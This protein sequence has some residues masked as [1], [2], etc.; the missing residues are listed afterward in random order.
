MSHVNLTYHIVWRTKCS[1][2]TINENN[3]RELYKYIVGICKGKNSHVYRINSMPDHIHLCVE[4]PPTIAVSTFMQ[5][6][7]QESSK[8]M[9]EHGELFPYFRGWGNGYAAFTYSSVE[10]L[11]VIDYIANQKEHHKTT[12][13][14][15][16][17]NIWL[18]EMGFNPLEDRFLVDD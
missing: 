1:E 4:I 7:K 8:W 9:S 10:R 15:E 12:N 18:K 13:F 17:Y 5:V 2:Q 16:E 11:R 14:K 3:E 6:L